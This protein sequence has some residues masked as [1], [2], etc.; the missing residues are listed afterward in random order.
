MIEYYVHNASSFAGDIDERFV[1]ITWIIGVSFF[2]TLSAFIYF[3]IRF[4][5][6]KGVRAEYIT[7]ENHKEKRFTHYPHYVVIALDVVI[8]AVNIIVWVHIKQTL[9][10]KDNLVRVIGQQWSWSFID[11]GPD[12]VLDTADDIATVNDLHV[13]V[14]ETYHFELQ[15]RDV[16]HN[17][18]VPVFR[19][20]QDGLPGRTI[21]GWFKPTKTGTFDIQC[22][23]MCGYGHGIMGGAITVHTEESYNETIAQIK[24]GTYESHYQKRMGTK[25][26][27]PSD[28]SQTN[29]EGSF[30]RM[31][32][33]VF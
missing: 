7:G 3:I 18:S 29:E 16:I 14:D 15:A 23:E 19:L 32:A 17:F 9:P 33:I 4:R 27:L 21:K 1:V 22:A 28:T 6:K 24:N 12:G 31:L 20:R 26:P 11:A 30:A 13:K 2:L 25:T 8:I 10:P 5:R